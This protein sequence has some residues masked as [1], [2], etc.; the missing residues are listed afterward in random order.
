M[1]DALLERFYETYGE[2]LEDGD[3]ALFVGCRAVGSGGVRRLEGVAAE[4]R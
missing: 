3:A 1:E 4:D 2:A